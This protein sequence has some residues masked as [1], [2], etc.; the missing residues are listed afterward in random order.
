M[1][2]TNIAVARDNAGVLY[3]IS[4]GQLRK[5]SNGGVHFINLS[6]PHSFYH[7]A[8]IIAVA[9][10]NSDVVAVVDS[11]TGGSHIWLSTNGGNLWNDIG[12]PKNGI[13]A[14]ITDIAIS[15]VIEGHSRHYFATIADDRRGVTIRGDVMVR[16]GGNWSGINGV[17]MTHD[18]LAIQ[19]S[20][21]YPADSTVCVVGV[22]PKDGIDYQVINFKDK[23]VAR[24]I[25]FL[26]AG[27]IEDYCLPASKNSVIRA[28]IVIGI[29]AV[30]PEERHKVAFISVACGSMTPT[31]GIYRVQDDFFERLNVCPQDNGLRIRCLDY[32]G[33]GLL[34]GELGSTNV[35]VSSNPLNIVPAWDK[36]EP[37]P[38]GEREAVVGM[39]T[40]DCY[41][42][43]SGWNGGFFVL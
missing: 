35:W 18:Y 37:K 36:V 33:E 4:D 34:A 6:L 20:P 41:V 2:V 16:I 32:D 29:D 12:N 15:P 42:G 38:A 24:T 25:K 22:T 10:D 21:E 28:D 9:P 3:I 40:P 8:R 23:S 31:D 26:S 1:D 43:T 13:N 19:A 5:S 11:R 39:R 27:T 7:P 30:S 17:S 14:V